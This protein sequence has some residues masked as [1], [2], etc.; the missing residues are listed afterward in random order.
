MRAHLA[1]ERNRHQRRTLLVLRRSAQRGGANGRRDEFAPG[2]RCFSCGSG[3][4]VQF[5][6]RS[7]NGYGP[8]PS[9]L[10]GPLNLLT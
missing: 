2:Q 8:V 5:N 3:N 10:C 4:G 7:R 9:I 6:I 1:I